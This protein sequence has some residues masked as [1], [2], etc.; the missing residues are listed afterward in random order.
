[1]SA[2]KNRLWISDFVKSVS[3]PHYKKFIFLAVG[4][5]IQACQEPLWGHGQMK[6]WGP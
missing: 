1:M 2:V 5:Y 3:H 6:K 4:A